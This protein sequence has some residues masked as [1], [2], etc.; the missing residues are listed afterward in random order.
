M[1]K[2]KDDENIESVR[3]WKKKTPSPKAS[4]TD[5]KL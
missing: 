2:H 4:E 1:Q 5:K 3:D